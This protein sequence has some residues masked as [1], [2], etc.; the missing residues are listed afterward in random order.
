MTPSPARRDALLVVAGLAGLAAFIVFYDRAFPQAAVKLQIT[1]AEALERARAVAE[2][3]GAPVDT[4][5][6]AA[7]FGG[8]T[9]GL[10]FL[11]RT[12]GLAEAGR[13]AREAVP[14]WSWDARWFRPEQKE[15]WKVALG[16]DGKM[17]RAEHLIEDAAPGDSLAKDA[18]QPLAEAYVRAQGWDLA[19]FDLVESSSQKRERRTDH[20]F[21]WEKRGSTIAWRAD[22]PEGGTGAVRLKV[23]IKGAAVGA[24]EHFLKLPEDFERDLTRN[25]SLGALVSGA[26][27]VLMFLL[28][29]AALILAVVR[30]KTGDIRWRPAL[31]LAGA[32]AVLAVAGAVNSLPPL[33]YGYPT[34][35]PWI[36]A[37]GFV[38]FM[39]FFVAVMQ[40]FE[41]VFTTAAGESLGR[42][43]FPASL[44][45]FLEMACGRLLMPDFARASVQGYALGLAL[46]GYL[47]LFYVAAQA[48]LGAWMPAE[49]PHGDVFNEYLPFLAPLTIG[50]IAAVSEEITFR[51]FG[52]SLVKRYLK[53]TAL[54]VLIPA[55]IWA[56]AHAN[57]PVFPVYVRGIELTIAGVLF[58]VAFLRLGLLTCIVAHFV[59][60]AVLVGMPLLTSGNTSYVISGVAV[61]GIALVPAVIGLIG[62]GKATAP[63]P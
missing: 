34:E 29:L 31:L 24:Y 14:I 26:S 54:A 35:V 25:F 1:R 50:V 7:V 27:F 51:L 52:I 10:L 33:K 30:H 38:V 49:G 15:E 46:L 2:S 36:A 32:T 43:H 37:I 63:P 42:Q 56:F 28:I 4:L 20:T 8:N 18:A 62:R 13:W 11:Q 3:L 6:E 17:V 19:E 58:G 60:D 44:A 12:V 48:W 53:S 23:E 5:K 41:V 39:V 40:G 21:T 9:E 45:G 57:Y 16:V 22:D 47:T 55:A 61:M 59:I